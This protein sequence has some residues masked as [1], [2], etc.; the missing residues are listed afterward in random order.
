MKSVQRFFAR[1]SNLT[2]R[3]VADERLHE[4]MQDHLEQQTAA[5]LRAGMSTDEARRQAVLKFGAVEA[6]REE[7]LDELSLPFVWT[8]WQDLRYALRQLAASRGFASV[9]ILTIA[10]GIGATTAIYSVVDAVLLHPLPYPQPEQLVRIENDF[11]GIGAHDV[12]LSVPEWKDF[13]RS[14]IF[15]YVAP[16]RSGSVNVTGSSQPTRIQFK[17]VA[18]NYFAL[19]DVKPKSKRHG[20][21]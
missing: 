16:E 19:L 20:N 7:Y 15:R 13:E 17:S 4:E 14:G 2:A 5:N 12:Y 9:V 6:I 21:S 8:L 18:A 10:L 11:P 3:R 1:L